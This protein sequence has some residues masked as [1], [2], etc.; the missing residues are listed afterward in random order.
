M[1]GFVSPNDMVGN[2]DSARI[3]AAIQ[4]AKASGVNKVVI[5]RYNKRTDSQIWVIE[6]T[7]TL[8][9]DIE[10]VFDHAHLILAEGKYLNMFA[11][12]TPNADG[13]LAKDATKNI[14]LRGVGNAT[15]DGGVYNGLSERN[16]KSLGIDIY[17]NTTIL[18]FNVDGL[19]VE[20]LSVVN[21]RWWGITNV[22]VRNAT[23]RNIRFKADYS[24]FVDGV[25]YP[26][27]IPQNYEEIYV[28][29]ADGIDLRIGC[30]NFTIENV[31]GFVEDDGVALTALG[32]GEI[33]RGM[34][35]RDMDTAIHDVTIKNVSIESRCSNVRLLNDNGHKLYNVTV[36]GVTSLLSGRFQNGSTIRIGDMAYAKAHSTLGDTHDIHIRNVNVQSY[37]GISIVKGLV[38]ATIE[39][40]TLQEGAKVGVRAFPDSC[41]TLKNCHIDRI[42]FVDEDAVAIDP[43]NITYVD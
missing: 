4:K 7:I 3:S 31:T 39:N 13:A 18:L 29:N 5:P 6:E 24:R 41:A 35:V 16:Y 23:Y 15:L 28:K 21:Q 42:T 34:F 17:R 10:I 12:G 26:D 38:N 36:D 2:S 9:S 22:F 27:Q 25:H 20:N 32:T 40:V 43:T 14:T 8:P 37:S 1:N 11:A 30:N 33:E 19:T